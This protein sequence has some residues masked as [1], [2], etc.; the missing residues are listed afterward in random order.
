MKQFSTLLATETER[1]QLVEGVLRSNRS[2][3]TEPSHVEAMLLEWF[4]MGEL[5]LDQTLTFLEAASEQ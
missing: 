5:T 1:Q 3:A 4:V 2:K